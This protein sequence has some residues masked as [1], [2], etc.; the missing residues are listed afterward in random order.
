MP[1]L[2][3][4]PEELSAFFAQF[5]GA[6]ADGEAYC[7]EN[8]IWGTDPADGIAF[9]EAAGKTDYVNF[10]KQVMATPEY[11][12][13]NGNVITMGTSYQVFNPLTGAHT[14]Y[15]DEASARA[16]VIEISKQVLATYPVSIVQAISNENGDS[17]WTPSSLSTPLNIS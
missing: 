11:V 15:Q 14:E 10:I 17:A 4:T 6:C 9:L 3:Y 8:N 7:K 5:G 16:A 2:K 1:Q 13:F 12:K